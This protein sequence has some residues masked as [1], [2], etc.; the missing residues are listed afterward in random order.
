MAALPYIPLFVADYLADTAHLT[1]AQHGAY[2]LLIMNYWQR[3][4]PLPNDDLRLAR[5]ARMNRRDWAHNRDTIIEFFHVRENLLCHDRIDT[6]LS[7]VA[8]KSLKSQKAAQASVQRRFS[9]RSTN[10][11]PTDTQAHTEEEA[12]A[13]SIAAE[14]KE[15]VVS[16]LRVAWP[17]PP[18]VNPNHWRDFLKN[19]K[20]KR[21]TNSETAY[22]GQ[23]REL[24]KLSD[25]EWPPGRLVQYAAEKGWGSINDPRKQLHERPDS[26]PL[27]S[28]VSR[29]LRTG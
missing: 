24:A 1:P 7:R 8:A 16:C 10:V 4:G 28:A 12:N 20:T 15:A 13:S 14:R 29:I 21:L 22:E 11:E 5:I 6:E 23:V 9:G 3:G 26:N 17:C 25:D 18:N 2:L 27:H 19:R